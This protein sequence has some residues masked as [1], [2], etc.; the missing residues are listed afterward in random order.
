MTPEQLQLIERENEW[1]RAI[2]NRN[3][4][5]LEEILADDYTNTDAEGTVWTKETDLANF[6]SNSYVARSLKLTEEP[7]VRVYGNS[8]VVTGCDEVEAKFKDVDV[9]GP[10]RWTD[11]W[12]RQDENSPWR[13]VASHGSRI[14]YSRGL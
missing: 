1:S 11:T 12:V 10:Y 13:C 7:I 9:S 8:A 4:R 3:L 6:T 2:L 14:T 5:K